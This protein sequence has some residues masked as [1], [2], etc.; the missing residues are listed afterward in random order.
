MKPARRCAVQQIKHNQGMHAGL[1]LDK[2]MIE[3][4]ERQEK[5]TADQKSPTYMHVKHVVNTDVPPTYHR[6]FERWQAELKAC[7]AHTLRADVQGRLSIGLGDE[8]VLE[9]SITLHHTY[10]VPYLP[11]SA[12]KGLAASFARQRLGEAW[13]SSSEAYATMFGSTEAAGYVTFFDALY[14]P[15]SGYQ[16]KPLHADV[17]TVH[18]R[19]Y[20]EGKQTAP[21]DWD[22]PTPVPFV[23]ATGTF[24][25]ALAGPDEAWTQAA[26][27]ILRHAL[28]ERGIGA[29][30]SSG[31]GRMALEEP[32]PDHQRQEA[33]AVIKRIE[34]LPPK[35]VPNQINNF[36]QQWEKLSLRA[37]L[38]R[39]VAQAIVDKVRAAGREKQSADKIWYKTL[40][41][42]IAE[43][44]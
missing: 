37:E 20:Y 35:D 6:F 18:H 30:T 34:N 7:G 5:L 24:L 27:N 32:P 26:F 4:L 41:A 43:T 15:D 38:K 40:L 39:Q 11:G 2:Y 21:A 8:S 17:L 16:Q 36:F 12:L 28:H 3:L 23:V 1:W 44:A 19:D 22:S 14:V 13:A 42:Y 10:G 31:Y 9:T 33:E 25:V 29:K